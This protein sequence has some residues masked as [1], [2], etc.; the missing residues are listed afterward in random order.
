MNWIFLLKPAKKCHLFSQFLAQLKWTVLHSDV[1]IRFMFFLIVFFVY[2]FCLFF[3]LFV[4]FGFFQAWNSLEISF[5]QI[6]VFFLLS[7]WIFC[8]LCLFFV[9]IPSFFSI[10]RHK[11]N[12]F[13]P[14]IK[15]SH[16]FKLIVSIL[17]D[18]KNMLWILVTF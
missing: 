15:I 16:F 3:C 7:P 5:F 13:L 18:W 6:M 8:Q 2:S 9:K 1:F 11:W 12:I 10:S 17:R 14:S 4:Y